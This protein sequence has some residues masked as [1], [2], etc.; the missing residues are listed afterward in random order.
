MARGNRSTGTEV[1]SRGSARRPI[2]EAAVSV[3]ERDGYQGASIDD[4]ADVAGVSR[5]TV[6][7][8]FKTKNDIL[9][10]ATLEQAHLFLVDLRRTVSP[11]DDF[12]EFV[13]SCL[14]FVIQKAPTSRFFMLQMARG[15][16]TESATIYF[17]HPTLMAEWMD[18]FRE[19]YIKA[20]RNAQINPAIELH[21]LLMW[22]GRV[23]TSFLQYP[24]PAD[25]EHDLR[26]TLDIFVG[27]A[28]RHGSRASP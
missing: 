22:F 23:A 7:H 9:V 16:A 4:I 12:P 2:L 8:H 6:Y 3:F 27:G 19:P 21:E 5:R 17:N 15:V 28:L 20:L 1:T 13:V 24:S 26:T 25:G 10:A 18:H 11:E 14:C